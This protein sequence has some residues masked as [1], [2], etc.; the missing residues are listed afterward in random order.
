L[1][2]SGKLR[3][4]IKQLEDEKR[5]MIEILDNVRKEVEAMDFL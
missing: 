5:Y 2:E 1:K 3:E 4:E